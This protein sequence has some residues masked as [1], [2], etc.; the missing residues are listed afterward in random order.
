MAVPREV[1]FRMSHIERVF[2][3]LAHHFCNERFG[4]STSLNGAEEREEID[5]G[6]ERKKVGG[7]HCSQ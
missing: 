2:F 7:K 5:M 4:V 1:V 3:D 6:R